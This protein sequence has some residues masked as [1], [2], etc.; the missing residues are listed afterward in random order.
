M[1]S[2]AHPTLRFRLALT[3][4][5]FGTALSLLL[6][7]GLYFDFTAHGLGKRLMDETL[8]AEIEDYISRRTR[9]PNSPPPST[10]SIHGYLLMQGKSNENIPPELLG[11]HEGIYQMTL[12]NTPYRVAVAERNGV[13]YYMLFNENR[14]NRREEIFIL[15]LVSGAFI[16]ILV[17]V[18]VGRWLARSAIPKVLA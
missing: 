6:S 13:R 12:N 9:N 10:L 14:Q 1:L 2:K 4:A 3:F 17:S 18:W 5:A 7:L 15:Y 11:L 16:M 8:R